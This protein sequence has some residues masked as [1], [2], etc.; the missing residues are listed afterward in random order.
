MPRT[1]KHQLPPVRRYRRFAGVGA[2]LSRMLGLAV[3]CGLIY[4][5]FWG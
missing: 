2:F 5:F 1:E 3:V 4:F